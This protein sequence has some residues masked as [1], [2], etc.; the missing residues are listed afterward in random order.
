MKRIKP[1]PQ[2]PCAR[3]GW[4]APN[5]D[6]YPCAY[7]AHFD[8]A[9]AI[10]ETM[11][12]PEDRGWSAD[13]CLLENKWM[14]IVGQG[15]CFMGREKDKNERGWCD[16]IE[17]SSEQL[18]TLKNIHAEFVIARANGVNFNES[19]I[20]NPE[21]YLLQ[22]WWTPPDK[23]HNIENAILMDIRRWSGERPDLDGVEV[24]DITLDKF[25]VLS[26]R[27]GEHSG[28]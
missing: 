18:S 19:L 24:M 3:L 23:D 11:F 26:K 10:M 17:P 15:L 2:E 14:Q 22:G 8:C 1:Q 12:A 16:D 27:P 7:C 25:M 20:K 6:F 13:H 9:D 28:D 21:K 4:I 5:G